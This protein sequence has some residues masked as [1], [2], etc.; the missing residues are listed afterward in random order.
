MLNTMINSFFSNKISV[1]YDFEK[2]VHGKYE[3]A[4]TYLKQ[5]IIVQKNV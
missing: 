4:K 1:Q 2:Q 5:F 3:L